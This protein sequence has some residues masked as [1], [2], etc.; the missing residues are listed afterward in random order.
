MT[1]VEIAI[2]IERR[3]INLYRRARKLANDPATLELLL[4]LETEETAHYEYFNNILKNETAPPSGSDE[5]WTSL[6]AASLA[7]EGFYPGGL[8]QVA[9]DD[10]FA[11]P[12]NLLDS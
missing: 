9:Y 12:L 2:E 1:G 3:G 4:R 7:A 5:A 6:Y 8:M 10:A 11:S